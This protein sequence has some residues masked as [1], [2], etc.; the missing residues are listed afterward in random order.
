VSAE[1]TRGPA[2]KHIEVA[3]ENAD[4]GLPVPRG[5][6]LRVVKRLLGRLM[7][8]FGRNQASYNHAMVEAVS[9]LANSVETLRTAIPEH[10]GNEVGALHSHLG[11]LEV[12]VRELASASKTS[13]VPTL[14]RDPPDP[15]APRVIG[16]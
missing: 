4:L 8:V 16:T 12:E 9:E 11:T 15:R 10:V 5:T 3:A 13:R 14:R 6:R 7:W 2:S 1:G